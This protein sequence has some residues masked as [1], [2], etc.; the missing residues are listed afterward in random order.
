MKKIISVLLSLVM[1]FNMRCTCFASN[2]PMENRRNS[3]GEMISAEQTTNE[4]KIML[5]YTENEDGTSSYYSYLNGQL[6]GYTKFKPGNN[7]Y[8]LATCITPYSRSNPHWERIY[9]TPS[10]NVR[11]ISPRKTS[12]DIGYMHYSNSMTG[13]VFSIF[14][15][16]D[17]WY[18]EEKTTTIAGTWA[19][20][21]AFTTWLVLQIGVLPALG[22]NIANAFLYEGL[23]SLVGNSVQST[24][25][26]EV[27]ANI[28]EQRIYGNSTTHPDK[29]TGDLGEGQIVYVTTDNTSYAGETFYSGYT[30]HDWGTVDLGRMMFWKVYGIEYTPTS[31]TGLEGR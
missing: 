5:T 23:V 6:T 30:T 11:N 14:C 8:D 29:P 26:T 3:Y 16:V 18:L 1:C 13:E 2:K 28:V 15:Y 24:L 17:E 21:A 12:R 4:G 31:W 10:G 19:N 9:V 7:Y 25:S 20:M 27:T 22:T